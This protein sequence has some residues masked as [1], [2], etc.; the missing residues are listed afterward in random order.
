M[1]LS[2]FLLMS[3]VKETKGTDL[4]SVGKETV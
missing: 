4:E 2:M 1:V 3:K